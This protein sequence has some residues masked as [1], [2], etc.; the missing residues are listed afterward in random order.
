MN[1]GCRRA[2]EG[3]YRDFMDIAASARDEVTRWTAVGAAMGVMT[4]MN[5]LR[6]C[7]G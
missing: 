4:A 6:E 7:E 2:L 5:T 1:P 3:L